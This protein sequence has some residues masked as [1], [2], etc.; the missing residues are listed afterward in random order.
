MSLNN[1]DYDEDMEKEE[2]IDNYQDLF[3]PFIQSLPSLKEA[4]IHI[5][6]A[7]GQNENESN[8]LANDIISNCEQRLKTKFSEIQQKYPEITFDEAKIITSYTCESNLN[9]KYSPFR[10]LNQNL[11][12]ENRK[13]GIKYISKYLFILLKSLRQL[14][15]YYPDSKDKY[16][17]RCINRIVNYKID[18]FNEKNVPCWK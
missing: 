13:Q 11:V 8:N 12:S 16:L 7:A 17:Y 5:F 4:L 18:T 1:Y 14:T 3:T 2:S 6:T 9:S 10:I 15:R